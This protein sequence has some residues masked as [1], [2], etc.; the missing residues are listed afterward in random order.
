M[1]T[2]EEK[3]AELES[4]RTEYQM[5]Q[6]NEE[7]DAK[8]VK[9]QSLER[10]KQEL[11]SLKEEYARLTT[12]EAP[13]REMKLSDAPMD[14]VAGVNQFALDTADLLTSPARLVGEFM[15]GQDVR[16][17]SEV[18]TELGI[19]TGRG[20]YTPD[21]EIGSWLQTA[22]YGLGMGAGMRPVMRN[23]GDTGSVAADIAG[24]GMSEVSELSTAGRMVAGIR[25]DV[26][27][28]AR[29]EVGAEQARKMVDADSQ[30][31]RWKQDLH[32]EDILPVKSL[33]NLTKVLSTNGRAAKL[34]ADAGAVRADGT[35][36]FSEAGRKKRINAAI[37]VLERTDPVAANTLVRMNAVI[38][39]IQKD[40]RRVFPEISDEFQEGYFPLYK[41]S[42]DVWKGVTRESDRAGKDSSTMARETGFITE[43]QALKE[44]ENPVNNFMG[45]FEDTVDALALA[46]N[47]G[48][49]SSSKS[50]KGVNNYTENIIKA[51]VKDQKGKIGEEA[52]N[53]LG[54][55]L[56]LYAIDGR[57][58]M[59]QLGNM[60][61]TL[62]HSAL[63]GTPENA[64]L[65]IGDLGQAAYATS[66]RDALKGLPKALKSVV[67]TDGDLVV[68]DRGME[69]TIRM[70]DLGLTRQH[71]TEMVNENRHWLPKH[72]TKVGDALMQISGVRKANRLGVETNL[73]AQ[74]SQMQNLLKNGKLRTSP[75]A[76]GLDDAGYNR[77]VKGL[78]SGN[79]RDKA[80]LDAV[81][82]RLG[83]FQPV[84]RTAMP[85]E[86]LKARNGR[87]L[88]SMKMYMTK[89]ASRFNEDVLEKAYKAQKVGLDTPQGKALMGQAVVNLGRYGT[90]VL[91]LNAI[92]DPGRK[93]LFRGK[94]SENSYPR[95]FARQGVSFATGGL[96]DIDAGKY[97]RD[98]ATGLV[99]PAVKAGFTPIEMAIKALEN[100]EVTPEDM[101]RAAL[102]VPGARQILWARDTIEANE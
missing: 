33:D 4:L 13:Q 45:F 76:E 19:G 98:N 71:L 17:P 63:L 96:V 55:H 52:A 21:E 78:E 74:Y 100:G 2:L 84:S 34:L 73:N 68:T 20:S 27:M 48:V 59:G 88:W 26:Y 94:E 54:T 83:R 60:L 65:Q 1:S 18:A 89:M 72:V 46:R 64:V 51:I 67:L 22:G 93:E 23:P 31:M 57:K 82:F 97:G 3:K 12:P 7:D 61:R 42:E 62:S 91:A 30:A 49:K 43:E 79:V 99:P 81:F 39:S 56:A 70:A 47:Y 101:E 6:L 37:D 40:M 102:F 35:N 95:E 16:S 11:A 90:F 9:E 85:T 44:F 24:L 14:V 86:Y 28:S 10:K 58:S 87:L 69:N 25:D 92:V 50:L 38:G 80:V 53:R 5:Y 77:L 15:T 36:V 8:R 32:R 75:Y 29:T 41:K 66:F